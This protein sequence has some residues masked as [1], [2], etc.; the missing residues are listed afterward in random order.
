MV[1]LAH[2]FFFFTYSLSL[3]SS[4]LLESV[5]TLTFSSFSAFKP[6][7]VLAILYDENAKKSLLRGYTTFICF[8]ELPSSTGKKK[9]ERG[10]KIDPPTFQSGQRLFK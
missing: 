6:V 2:S 8:L 4:A 1:R 10:K 7:L 9:T 5:L 3:L